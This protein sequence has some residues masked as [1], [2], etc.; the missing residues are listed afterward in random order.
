MEVAEI[1]CADAELS[2]LGIE[3]TIELTIPAGGCCTVFSKSS[4][5]GVQ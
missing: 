4:I 2:M 5:G 1:E 3:T